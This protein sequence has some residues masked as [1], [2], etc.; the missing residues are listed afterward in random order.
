[1]SKVCKVLV[2]KLE[3][4]KIIFKSP[5]KM[6]H[7]HDFDSLH[8]F[9]RYSW[10]TSWRESVS[11]FAKEKENNRDI[12]CPIERHQA[13]HYYF[14]FSHSSWRYFKPT[15]HMSLS[16]FLHTNKHIS[17]PLLL[18]WWKYYKLLLSHRKASR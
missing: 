10:L 3:E 12:L 4:T 8:D 6:F 14:Y 5:R 18:S 16:G 15:A 7:I 2:W 9:I 11:A 13:R 17:A 1:M